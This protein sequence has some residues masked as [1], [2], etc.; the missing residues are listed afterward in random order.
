MIRDDHRRLGRFLAIAAGFAVASIAAAQ[1]TNNDP[2]SAPGQPVRSA[3]P[4]RMS[5]LGGVRSQPGVRSVA[6]APIPINTFGRPLTPTPTTT[7]TP[8]PPTVAPAPV[9]T[10]G[11]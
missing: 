7:P 2:N 4:P 3:A 6:P 5:G 1:S 9:V 11:G 10:T 8:P